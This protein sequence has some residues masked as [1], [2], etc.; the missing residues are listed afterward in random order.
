MLPYKEASQSGIAPTA[1]AAGRFV[2]STRVGGL[3]E[4]LGNESLATLCELNAASLAAGLRD[5]LHASPA[6]RPDPPTV[7]PRLAWRDMGELLLDRIDFSV[8]A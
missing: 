6:E 2:V 5:V 7:N 1:I 4:Q 8:R 3:I